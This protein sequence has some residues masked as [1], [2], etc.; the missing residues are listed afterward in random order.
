M[1]GI[2]KHIFL[3]GPPGVGKTTVGQRL[4]KHLQLPFFD[5]DAEVEKRTGM[6][7]PAIFH[8]LGEEYFRQKEQE[9]LTELV[10]QQRS[11]ITLGGG[12]LL[13]EKNRRIAE[14]YGKVIVLFA[15]KDELLRRNR[16]SEVTR[17][18]LID[19]PELSLTRLLEGRMKHYQSFEINLDTTDCSIEEIMEQISI[20]AGYF[21]CNSKSKPYPVIVQS[22]MDWLIEQIRNYISPSHPIAFI[23]DSNIAQIHLNAIS[24]A[25][26]NHHPFV[27][28]VTFPAGEMHKNLQTISDIW[29][30]L[31]AAD[32]D[33]KSTLIGLGGGVTTDITGFVAATYL[34]GIP[35]IAIPTTLLGMIDASIGGKTGVDFGGG[36]NIIGS[37]NSP[38]CVLIN[39]EYLTTLPQREL[40]AGLAEMIK[41]GVIGDESILTLLE[42]TEAPLSLQHLEPL[43]KKAIAVK[44]RV[45]NQDLFEKEIRASLNFGHTV[46]HA[47]EAASGFKINHGE[48]VALGMV[49]E[50]MLAET[51]GICEQGLADRLYRLLQRY[52]LPVRIPIS[53][54]AE[55]IIAHMRFD[56]KRNHH[57]I[58]FSLP[59]R[60]GEVGVKY[61]PDNWQ[62][63]LI[64][65]I[66]SLS[67]EKNTRS[68]W[69]K[70]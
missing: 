53:I 1:V 26:K 31:I 23:S 16:T 18:L 66:R 34:R 54:T 36:K 65:I 15:S 11:V 17:P 6:N 4:A 19:N 64:K 12:A 30:T 29:K 44:I 62:D 28:D 33:R 20:R 59:L 32:V 5:L 51:I 7:I 14:S 27:Y 63:L 68:T 13:R 58:T 52:G 38:Q 8:K 55:E 10:Q 47:I 21:L 48:A 50:T 67:D 25:L 49:C 40:Y 22:G 41:H 9:T 69:S 46:G 45:V 70:S 61:S 35:W 56:K 42:D 39:P 43:I 60:V 57:T 3:Y 24:T 2:N 37:F